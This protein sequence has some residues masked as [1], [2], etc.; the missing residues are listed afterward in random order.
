MAKEL[1]IAIMES[2]YDKIKITLSF[3]KTGVSNLEMII[4]SNAIYA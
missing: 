3:W 2:N 1:R 4:K